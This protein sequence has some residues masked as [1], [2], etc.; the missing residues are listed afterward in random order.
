MPTKP[1]KTNQKPTQ[2]ESKMEKW[3]SKWVSKNKVIRF[4]IIILL[5]SEAIWLISVYWPE[6]GEALS[7]L[8]IRFV[9]P[10]P[11]SCAIAEVSEFGERE[12]NLLNQEDPSLNFQRFMEKSSDEISR[13]IIQGVKKCQWEQVQEVR[14]KDSVLIVGNTTIRNAKKSLTIIIDSKNIKLSIESK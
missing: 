11:V 9:S 7:S 1:P 14:E 6:I 5:L 8:S 10:D 12:Y 2:E 13:E 3:F 4:L